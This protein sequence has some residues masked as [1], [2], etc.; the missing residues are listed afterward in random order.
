MKYYI[1]AACVLLAAVVAIF[2]TQMQPRDAHAEWKRY[3]VEPETKERPARFDEMKFHPVDVRAP[4]SAPAAQ[5]S[6]K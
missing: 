2:T 3:A 6:E 1:L 4:A 5:K